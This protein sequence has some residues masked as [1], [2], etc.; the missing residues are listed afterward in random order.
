MIRLNQYLANCG[1]CSRRKADSLIAAGCVTID[2]RPAKVGESVDP[3]RHQVF[4]SG[5]RVQPPASGPQT[6]VLNKPAGV[7]T[8]LRDERGRRSVASLL[9]PTP[10]YFPIG[11]LDAES[12]GVLL[13][14]TDGDLAHILTHPSFGVEKLYRVRVSGNVTP[15]TK[16]AL[17]ALRVRKNADATIT[18]DIVLREGRNRQVRRM[19]AQRGLR[20]LELTRLKFGPVEIGRLEPGKT[21]ALTQ[22]EKNA[23]E[24]LRPAQK[25]APVR[26]TE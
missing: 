11:R 8:T 26:P 17:Q 14:T 23:L 18:F 16:A 3:S 9:P 13:C 19:C 7:V 22:T 21:R 12:T 6:I 25:R 5:R 2:G 10:R 15:A 24:R 4:V 1:L 20:V